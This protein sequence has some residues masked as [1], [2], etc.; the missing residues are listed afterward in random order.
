MKKNI[1]KILIVALLLTLALPVAA[2]AAGESVTVEIPFTVNDDPGTVTMKALDGAPAPEKRSF[3]GEKAGTFVLSC[4]K[5]GDY[6]YTIKETGSAFG[7]KYDE[8]VYKVRV[9]VQWNEKTN[10][11][12][13]VEWFMIADG[14]S[15]KKGSADFTNF[16]VGDLT[17]ENEIKGATTVKNSDGTETVIVNE[18]EI[19]FTPKDGASRF[20]EHEDGV[21]LVT[22]DGKKVELTK[23]E[24]GKSYSGSFTLKDG[25]SVTFP[26]LPEGTGY[27][28]QM[29][30]QPGYDVDS[31]VTGRGDS[32]GT[33]KDINGKFTK[34]GNV[35]GWQNGEIAFGVE[36]IIHF[37]VTGGYA[38]TLVQA[39]SV[40]SVADGWQTSDTF[41]FVQNFSYL[42]YIAQGQNLTSE[43]QMLR[44]ALTVDTS[45]KGTDRLLNVEY[46]DGEYVGDLFRGGGQARARAIA[47]SN[48]IYGDGWMYNPNSHMIVFDAEEVQPGELTTQH[49]IRTSVP[50]VNSRTEFTGVATLMPEFEDKTLAGSQEVM[51]RAYAEW[52]R[53]LVYVGNVNDPMDWQKERPID[54]QVR[55]YDLKETNP[56]EVHYFL[57]ENE[58]DYGLGKSGERESYKLDLTP[59]GDGSYVGTITLKHGQRVVFYDLHED[60]GYTVTP[61]LTKEQN[62]RYNG[63]YAVYKGGDVGYIG[64]GLDGDEIDMAVFRLIPV[65]DLT[66]T[67]ET[68][69]V[70]NAED[71]E[72]SFDIELDV[73][74]KFEDVNREWLYLD[75]NTVNFDDIDGEDDVTETEPNTWTGTITLSGAGENS[76]VTYT[77][78]PDGSYYSVKE[79]AASAESHRTKMTVTRQQTITS[80]N[81]YEVDV[82][83]PEPV[84]TVYENSVDTGKVQFN[85][86]NVTVTFEN[87][88]VYD[89]T[90]DLNGGSANGSK[91]SVTN[92]HTH[93]DVVDVNKEGPDAKYDGLAFGGWSSSRH[94]P[95]LTEKPSDI[96][97]KVDFTQE[98]NQHDTTLYAIWA[99]D[100]NG[101][102]IPDYDEKHFTLH[103]DPN[104]GD[105]KV[106]ADKTVVT[107][108]TVELEKQPI[109]TK[110]G[111]VWVGWSETR[112]TGVFTEK[113]AVEGVVVTEVVVDGNKT[114]YAVWAIDANGNGI[115]DYD[116]EPEPTETPTPTETPEPTETPT[117]TETPAPSGTPGG[118]SGTKPPKTGDESNI[119]LWGALMGVSA[120]MICASP[121]ILLIGK[122]GQKKDET[123]T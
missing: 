68:V 16:K 48:I 87:T 49:I 89:L 15:H 73:R 50:A 97:T 6:W 29:Q 61:D 118:S 95:G 1:L 52:L 34:N 103:Y 92:E 113:S 104:G 116:E 66:V 31:K 98:A 38:V 12:E 35:I 40:D 46:I 90:F 23:S 108:V 121:I 33:A 117:T 112:H 5:P 44:V 28:V 84:V 123:N 20:F 4:T 51:A 11:L 58:A 86:C 77:G 3:S 100:D 21:Y 106:P 17:I 14:E 93:T 53:V 76:S 26:G 25:E 102:G 72:Y 37:R 122:K 79:Q 119:A 80:D 91:D 30:E 57:F 115:P 56:N 75:L 78:I 41:G 114:V 105:G 7:I 54:F 65:H 99:T 36:D 96:V 45:T 120:L 107:G 10:K 22:S 42:S 13:L 94:E 101:N 19:T 62:S 71:K 32:R 67:K 55:L 85:M 111:A 18:F 109:P 47:A 83:L 59:Q 2:Y 64:A 24:D 8:T 82:T 27:N 43:P 81:P 70:P 39:S 60:E 74:D 9:Y 63:R 110:P 88:A 69:G